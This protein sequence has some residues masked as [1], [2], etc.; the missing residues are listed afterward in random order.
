MPFYVSPKNFTLQLQHVGNETMA[1]ERASF[2]PLSGQEDLTEYLANRHPGDPLPGTE[3]PFVYEQ[4][5]QSQFLD[6]YGRELPNPVPMAPPLGYKKS[7]SIA[8]QMRQMIRT[9]SY[10]AANAGA[11]TEEEANDFDVGEDMDPSTPYEN[12]FEMDPALEAMIA[13][14]SRPPAPP[15]APPSSPAEPVPVAPPKPS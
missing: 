9:A 5:V 2:D 15:S 4:S 8:E 3:Q 10:E 11:E 1:K 7:M 14:Q 13:L 12:D 6:E